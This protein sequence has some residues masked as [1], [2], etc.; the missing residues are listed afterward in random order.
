[1]SCSLSV[2]EPLVSVGSLA[3]LCSQ[4]PHTYAYI[5]FGYFFLANKSHVYLIIRP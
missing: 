1:M 2:S 4:D 3:L 5:K